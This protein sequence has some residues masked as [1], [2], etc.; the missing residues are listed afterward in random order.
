MWGAQKALPGS[1][2]VE[3]SLSPSSSARKR[4]QAPICL[5]PGFRLIFCRSI[6]A[7]RGAGATQSGAAAPAHARRQHGFEAGK[8]RGGREGEPHR[9]RRVEVRKRTGPAWRRTCGSTLCRRRRQRRRCCR[10]GRRRR[11]RPRHLLRRPYSP[12][13]LRA[14]GEVAKGCKGVSTGAQKMTAEARIR[15]ENTETSVGV[16]G[17]R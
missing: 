15:R 16:W 11:R 1:D 8:L 3:L 9:K 6:K 7:R 13:E 4:Q 14:S 17:K 5:L 12:A 10:R 2:E